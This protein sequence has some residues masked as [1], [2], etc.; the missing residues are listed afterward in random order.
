MFESIYKSLLFHM[1]RYW[2]LWSRYCTVFYKP[3]L[4]VV[5]LLQ[6][7]KIEKAYCNN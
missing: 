4:F 6:F 3:P 5:S 2:R 1:D 7:L